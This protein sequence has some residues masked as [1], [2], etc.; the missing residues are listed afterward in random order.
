MRDDSKKKVEVEWGYIMYEG[1]H[2]HFRFRMHDDEKKF[3]SFCFMGWLIE[4]WKYFWDDDDDVVMFCCWIVD[5][6]ISISM[7]DEMCSI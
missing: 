7:W 2:K 5:V 6:W 3:N 1:E 4:E